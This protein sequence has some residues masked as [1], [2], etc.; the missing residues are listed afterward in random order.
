MPIKKISLLLLL[1]T[2]LSGTF[3]LARV[4]I[5]FSLEVRHLLL[6]TFFLF[7]IIG[8]KKAVQL[9][10]EY[11]SLALNPFLITVII[12][13]FAS[14][15][16]LFYT[17]D[18]PKGLVKLES[19]LFLLFLII[20][21][22]IMV[23]TNNPNDFFNLVSGFFVIIGI[24]YSFP[25]YLSVMSGAERGAV[26]LSGPNVV[27]RIL[28]FATCSSLYKFWLNKKTLY[29]VCTLI[30]LTSIVLVGSRG[31]L[32]GATVVLFLI[33]IIKIILVSW[34]QKRKVKLT[35]KKI[36]ILFLGIGL[37]L[38]IYQPV[39]R[40]FLTRIIGATFEGNGVYT[41]GRDVI[42][43]DA[44]KM[45]KEKP[46]FGHGIESFTLYTGHVY[47]HN[48]LL[49]MMVEIGLL[50]LIIFG[51]FV[52]YAVMLMFKFKTSPLFILSGIPLY[53]IIVQMFSGEFYDF[54]YFFLWSIPL[55]F[56]GVLG[57]QSLVKKIE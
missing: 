1:L 32:V 14:T 31:G 7:L 42:Y 57:S 50:G 28:F 3:T 29:I 17:I 6:L 11:N 21:V 30:F 51:I 13:F 20:S 56:Y 46:F 15:I 24:V 37:L 54:R 45:I 44:I 33:F 40:V 25:I 49:E 38:F 35:L 8:L 41:A 5:G 22:L 9:N 34:S 48:L 16:S 47:P 55:L 23:K 18:Q 26:E 19:V 43:T 27:T 36:L 2:F 4:N 52:F 12:Y 39:K 53:M 10:E